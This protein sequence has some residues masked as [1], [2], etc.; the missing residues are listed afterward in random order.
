MENIKYCP[1]NTCNMVGKQDLKIEKKHSMLKGQ[2]PTELPGF[3]TILEEKRILLTRKQKTQK[4]P[5][6]YH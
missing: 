5:F 6:D 2:L 1:S 4:T 3:N